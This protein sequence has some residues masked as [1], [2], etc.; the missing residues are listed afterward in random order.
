MNATWRCA[1]AA[2]D[3]LTGMSRRKNRP[4]RLL[5]AALRAGLLCSLLCGLLGGALGAGGLLGDARLAADEP[6]AVAADLA[7]L[8]AAYGS[9]SGK[10]DEAGYAAQRTI[11]ERIS[12]LRRPEAQR[13]LKTLLDEIGRGDRRSAALLLAAW[14]RRGSPADL[15]GA[16]TWVER[17]HDPRLLSLLH[18][19]VGG[20][21]EPATRRY[22]RENALARGVPAVKAELA[23]AVGGMGEPEGVVP[24][25]ALLGEPHLL[26]RVEAI[27]ALGLLKDARALGPLLA[28]LGDADA[29]LREA[30]A[31]ALGMI[32]SLDVLPHLLRALQ[33]PAPLVVESVA[34]A[35]GLLGSPEAIEPLIVRLEGAASVDLRLADTLGR[36]LER[37]TGRRLGVDAE[38]WRAWWMSVKDKPFERIEQDGVGS[39]VPTVRYHGFPVR[40]SKVIFVLDISRSMGWNGRLEAAQKELV[41]VLENLPRA[42]RFNLVVFSDRAYRWESALVPATLTQVRRATAFIQRQQPVA[43]TAA[44]AALEAAFADPEADTIFFL[45]DGHPSGGTVLDPELILADVATWNRYRRARVHAIALL[46]GEPPAAWAGVEDGVRAAEFMRRLAEENDGMFK[47]IR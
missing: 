33:D 18:H 41:S 40:S 5:A 43:G 6:P 15:D 32:G 12:D 4:G 35:L 26:V 28:L 21:L 30:A 9:L 46:I 3:V 14:V 42:S 11:L 38:Q 2:P 16:I 10:R 27:G 39:S 1:H 23:R 22:L 34:T 44:H 31:R 45:S 37:I 29:R 7:P 17:T 19:V 13:A 20:A 47:E 24:L 36:A 8:L 25:L